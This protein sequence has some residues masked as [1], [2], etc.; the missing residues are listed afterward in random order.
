MKRRELIKL[1]GAIELGPLTEVDA[2]L[3]PYRQLWEQHLDALEGHLDRKA[4]RGSQASDW[5]HLQQLCL[6]IDRGYP[7]ARSLSEHRLRM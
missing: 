5:Y 2:W 3:E 6:R 1:S 7:T 4:L